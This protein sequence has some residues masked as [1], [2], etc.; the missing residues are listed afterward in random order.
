M[1]KGSTQRPTNKTFFEANYDAIWGA[2]IVD[3]RPQIQTK[4]TAKP[5]HDKFAKVKSIR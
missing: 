1:S 3:N 5:A 2:K 4:D